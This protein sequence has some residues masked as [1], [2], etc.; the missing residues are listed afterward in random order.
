MSLVPT[1]FHHMLRVPAALLLGCVLSAALPAGALFAAPAPASGGTQ[2]AP[3]AA[4]PAKP[5]PAPAQPAPKLPAEGSPEAQADG[6]ARLPECMWLG[7]RIVSLLWRDDVNTAREQT[8]FYDRFGCPDD[9]LKLAF[10]CVLR[11]SE[12]QPQQTDIN[13]RI[14]GCWMSPEIGEPKAK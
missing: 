6:P 7:Q 14:Y 13:A 12:K 8:R 4:A 3:P 10:R 5:A 1:A 11:Q 2:P 9:H